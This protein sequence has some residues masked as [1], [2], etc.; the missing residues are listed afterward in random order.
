MKKS[1][2]RQASIL[3][4]LTLAACGGGADFTLANRPPTALAGPP[5]TVAVGDTVTL[6]GS[7]TDPDQDLL[8]YQWIFTKPDGSAAALTN[9]H[10]A[11]PIF[12]ADLAGT[13][14]A[15]L[16]VN[17]GKVYSAASTVTITAQVQAQA[18]AKIWDG[19]SCA[20]IRRIFVIDQHLVYTESH[21]LHCSDSDSYALYE[22]TPSRLLCRAGGVQG[23]PS[24]TGSA[25]NATLMQTILA[26][27]TKTDLGLGS[28]HTVQ[29]VY[30]Y[31]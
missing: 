23:E 19:S 29:Q 13:Y 20:D 3:M 4:A 12:I 18:F 9:A 16:Q 28:T 5:Q 30:A 22:S 2:K 31:P 11:T 15:S 1:I 10:V 25:S 14:T 26:N 8:T 7:G 17:D 21:A 27:L 6:A 24:C